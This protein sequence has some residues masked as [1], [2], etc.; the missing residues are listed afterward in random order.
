ML[1]CV[2]FFCSIF[3]RRYVFG[4]EQKTP[5]LRCFVQKN[6]KNKAADVSYRKKVKTTITKTF[7]RFLFA[8]LNK[9]NVWE[10]L[11]LLRKCKNMLTI[12]A[13]E[14]IIKPWYF[15]MALFASIFTETA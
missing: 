8:K 6:K 3:R 10:V 5:F 12:R 13:L 1:P 14:S 4:N 15:I 7:V 2:L 9:N 11:I